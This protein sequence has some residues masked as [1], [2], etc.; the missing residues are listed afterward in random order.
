[1]RDGNKSCHIL[2]LSTTNYNEGD[3]Q[4]QDDEADSFIEDED[5]EEENATPDKPPK[6]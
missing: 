1:M 6:K 3:S 5:E 4:F 2:P